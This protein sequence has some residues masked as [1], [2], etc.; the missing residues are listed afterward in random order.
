MGEIIEVDE[1]EANKTE[2]TKQ[3]KANIEKV[4]VDG[5]LSSL[6]ENGRVEYYNAV[7]KSLNLNPLTKPFDYIKLN[8]KLTLYANKNATEQLRKIYKVS[9]V[10]METKQVGDVMVVT[11]KV[12]DGLGRTDVS[13]GAVSVGNLRGDALANAIMKS[14]TKAKRRATLS[15]CGLGMLDETELETIKQGIEIP[16]QITKEQ[17][18]QIE[19]TKEQNNAFREI[20][21]KNGISNDKF[22][23]FSKFANIKS[24]KDVEAYL[25]DENALS[26]KISEFK[27]IA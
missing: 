24:K 26:Q 13:T 23:E 5:D 2:I 17:T 1:I 15:I 19:K 6:D 7:C 20:L 9:I 3:T 18:K 27:E 8:G 10:D 22:A 4:L 21:A 16:Q 25:N 11:C 12:Q 14:E